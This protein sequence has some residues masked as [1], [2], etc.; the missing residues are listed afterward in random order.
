MTPCAVTVEGSRGVASDT[1]F[2]TLTAAMSGLV[3]TA[4]VMAIDSVP[5]DELFERM[6]SMCSTPFSAC[7]SGAAT[8]SAMTSA[9]APGYTVLTPICGGAMF[10]YIATGS[11]R[12]AARPAITMKAETTVANSGR[13]MKKFEITARP[14]R[15]PAAT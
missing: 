12:N 6:Y 15:W 1:R 10:G 13:S 11:S 3:P 4:N 8:V 14:P 9:L 5:V 7:S 2:C